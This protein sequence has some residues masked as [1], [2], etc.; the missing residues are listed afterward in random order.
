MQTAIQVPGVI[1]T[2]DPNGLDKMRL[3][4]IQYATARTGLCL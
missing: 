3:C 1:R 2:Y 4:A